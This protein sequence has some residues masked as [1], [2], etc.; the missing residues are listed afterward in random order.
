MTRSA[1]E[2]DGSKHD[3]RSTVSATDASDSDQTEGGS[4]DRT[5]GRGT[6]SSGDD[7]A[8]DTPTAVRPG[9]GARWW[10]A[11]LL[12]ACWAHRRL[13]IGI[14]AW[15]VVTIALVTAGPLLTRRGVNDAVDGH[16]AGL[17]WLV[18]GLVLIAAIDFVGNYYRRNLAGRLSLWVQHELRAGAFGSIQRLDGHAQDSMRV[19]QVVSRTNSDLEQVRSMLQ[20]IPVPVS[21][22]TYFVSGTVVMVYLSPALTVVSLTAMALLGLTAWRARKRVF[23]T[24][25]QGAQE[26]GEL[27]ERIG[28]TIDGVR[29]VKGFSQQNRELGWLERAAR[30]VFG[31][32]M[33]TAR[34]QAAPGATMLA[35]PVLGQFA[36]LGYGGWLVHDGGLDIGT[37][38]AFVTFLTMLTGPTRV[39]ASFLVIAQRTRASAERIFEVIDS[40]PEIHDGANSMPDKLTHLRL[41]NV[42]FGYTADRPVLNGLDLHISAGETV[43]IIGP[44]GSGKSTISL[45]LPRFYD[46]TAGTI[47]VG[48]DNGELDLN[49]VRIEDLR[50]HVGT[51]FEDPFLFASSV[52]DNIAYGHHDA[53]AAEIRAAA[54]AAGADEF[55]RALPAGY[56]TI[57]AE[58]ATDLSGGQRQR[59]ALAR[60]LLRRPQ[61]LVID[62]STSAVDA[63]TESGILQALDNQ[64]SAEH[65][66]VLIARHRATLS[67]AD[68]IVVMDEGRVVD[69]GT[70]AELERRCQLYREL[71]DGDEVE[72]QTHRGAADLWPS[73]E[74]QSQEQPQP[75]PQ[76]QA[77]AQA[78]AADRGR[79]RD[80]I[81]TAVQRTALNSSIRSVRSVLRPVVGLLIVAFVLIAFDSLANV[82]TPILLQRG[83]DSGVLKGDF[84][85]VGLICALAAGIVVINWLVFIAQNVTTARASEAVQYMTRVRC[86][87]HMHSLDLRHFEGS[88]AGSL[89]TRMTVDIDSLARFM[90]TG[91]VNGIMSLV[92]MVGIA[93]AMFVFH[94][95]LAAVALASL[96]LILIATVVFRHLSSR[97]YLQARTEIRDV[98]RNL[99]EN[100]D[101]LRT[102]QAHGKQ[103]AAIS[104]FNRL[105]DKHRSTRTKAQQYIAVYFPFVSFLAETSYALVL[106]VGATLVAR[107]ELSPGVLIAFLLFL[108]QFYNPIQQL[109]NIAD[110]FMQ[111]ANGVRHIRELL[112]LPAAEIPESDAHDAPPMPHRLRNE[113][114]VDGLGFSYNDDAEGAL[115]DISLS[116]APGQSLAVVG[117]TGAGKTTLAKLLCRYYPQEAGRISLDGTPAEKFALH[118]YRLGIGEV[119]QEGYLFEGDIAENMRYGRPEAEDHEVAAAA[120]RVGAHDVVAG[121]EGGY[122][123]RVEAGGRNLSAGQRQLIALARTELTDP[124][125]FVLD[126]ATSSMDA[127]AESAVLDHVLTADPGRCSIIIAHHLTTAER[128]DRVAVLDNGRIVEIGRHQDLIAQNGPYAR[129]WND[130]QGP[131]ER[132]AGDMRHPIDGLEGAVK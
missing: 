22:V 132:S 112:A 57:L 130:S 96:P 111:A 113:L 64:R 97:A 131:G 79:G 119:A 88:E 123:H 40:R 76:P 63:T 41:E 6:A 29:V 127:Q 53:T 99:Q 94:P 44:S 17:A 118:D 35:L 87:G 2:K 77:Q 128:C 129:L 51:V 101:G 84:G 68:R 83:I 75:Q 42:S 98:N 100:I 8:Q 58:R 108:S 104:S 55:I 126:E 30:G 60:A 90:Q 39:F 86:F 89:M 4:T 26:V 73:N 13:S 23:A 62:D 117:R 48:T 92:T 32:R 7:R 61:I 103:K 50:R 110:S 115:S 74:T 65:I 120:Q 37:F 91:L 12:G 18:I 54:V 5:E 71:T 3:D 95:L 19:G 10:V 28:Q 15:S 85:Y 45:L 14:L 33:Q 72:Q 66:T 109:S 116:L 105:S 102:V 125:I 69:A 21:V 34:A 20:M 27:T 9:Q 56:D 78:Q 24:S 25:A 46:P 43:A 47:R 121:L 1:L 49:D 80:V 81:S 67:I 59:L 38:V 16:T 52:E 82:A 11:R 107:G 114:D 31:R 106:G 70:S 124:G 122:R 93:V 36:V